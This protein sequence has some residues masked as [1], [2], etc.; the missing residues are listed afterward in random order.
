M[1]RLLRNKKGFNW[2]FL[3]LGVVLICLVY[4]FFQLNSKLAS[5]S[6]I[7]PNQMQV[8]SAKKQSSDAL[9]Y[10]D[11][12][13]RLSA[14][15][16]I[17]DLGEKGGFASQIAC[18]KPPFIGVID[19]PHTYW[20]AKDEKC[21]ENINFYNEFE[22]LFKQHFIN[23]LRIYNAFPAANMDIDPFNYEFM[24]TDDLIVGSAIKNVEIPFAS[25]NIAAL[26]KYSFKP[27]FA[28]DFK[29]GVNDYFKTGEAVDKLLDCDKPMAQCVK[30][31][32]TPGLSWHF[33]QS[34][35]PGIYLF[36]VTQNSINCRFAEAK[37]KIKF[38][39]QKM[40]PVPGP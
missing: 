40:P 25:L 36:E 34:S 22:K 27:S 31:L 32:N 17:Y 18:N 5:L 24:I 10:I 2:A 29:T 33:T 30:D 7:G 35:M 11:Q 21:Y 28:I 26:S 19:A 13:S 15:N 16:A 23:Y 37:P 12:T 3:M 39:L 8:I 9:F 6:I 38:V 1:R 4:L 14:C 20:N